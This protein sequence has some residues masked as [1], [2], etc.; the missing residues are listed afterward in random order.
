[1]YQLAMTVPTLKVRTGSQ[2]AQ[3]EG[4]SGLASGGNLMSARAF[5]SLTPGHY[6]TTKL[7]WN[8]TVNCT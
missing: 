4:G 1:M 5:S 2:V 3:G 8:E 6:M 7:S